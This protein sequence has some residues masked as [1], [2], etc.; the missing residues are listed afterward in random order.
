[1]CIRDR[2]KA[3]GDG[4]ISGDYTEYEQTGVVDAGGVDVTVKGDG[5]GIYLALWSADGYSYSLSLSSPLTES[6]WL[7]LIEA[8][9]Q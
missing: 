7:A 5:D 3:E 9:M 2:R 4:D 6:E 1:M 8:N